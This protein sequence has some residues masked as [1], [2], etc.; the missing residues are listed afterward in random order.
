MAVAALV[1]GLSIGLPFELAKAASGFGN[2]AIVANPSPFDQSACVW[3]KAHYRKPG[4]VLQIDLNVYGYKEPRAGC[5]VTAP[6]TNFK[7]DEMQIQSFLYTSSWTFC[8]SSSALI[9]PNGG[10]GGGYGWGLGYSKSGDCASAT[11]FNVTATGN[12]PFGGSGT[13]IVSF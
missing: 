4:N 8:A 7:T 13:S 6:W 1:L 12:V 9:I 2:N 5:N 10:T 11:S 3:V